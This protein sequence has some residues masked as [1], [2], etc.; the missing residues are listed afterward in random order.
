MTTLTAQ[1]KQRTLRS[2]LR[3]AVLLAAGLLL[4][5]IVAA[6]FYD[7]SRADLIS[8]GVKAAGVDV[9]GMRTGEARAAL[10]RALPPRLNR[11]IVVSAAGHHLHFATAA[12][13]PRIDIDGLVNR[14][15]DES[16]SGWFGSRAIDG[17]T[18]ARKNADVS[19]PVTYSHSTLEALSARIAAKIDRN[20]RDA[21][22]QPS[23]TGLTQ[24]KSQTG[25]KLDRAAL[26][27]ALGAAITHPGDPRRVHAVVTVT[28]P[29]VT[30]AQ[31]ANK[32]PNYIIVDRGGF[33]L[34]YYH[35]LKL[36]KTYPIAVGMQGLETPAGLYDIQW[37]QVNPPWYVPNSA[38]AG[39]LAGK[40]IP[41]G[42]QDPLKARFMAFNGG[43]G[44]HG[45]D[46]S[47]YG[48]IGHNASHG[49]VRMT[50][51]DVIDLYQRV[52]VHTPV[53]VG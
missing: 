6:F 51:P 43:A 27:A 13:H 46:P 50:I 15:V 44:I 8:P 39:S 49:C 53:Y 19:A 18:G 26:N 33:T 45:I 40:T 36:A 2:P 14:A 4:A 5:A 35:D 52:P 47:E 48:S 9:G 3:I 25:R 10:E 42:P 24:V 28:H 38:W 30:T 20:A 34:R 41:P 1:L 22:V 16:R 17:I 23:A 32:Y 12:T 37:K 11:T 31:L 29:K 7:R 21:S